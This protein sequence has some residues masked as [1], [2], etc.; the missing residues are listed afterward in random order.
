MHRELD[1]LRVR[2]ND[3]EDGINALI[4]IYH[5]FQRIVQLHVTPEKWTEIVGDVRRCGAEIPE[6]ASTDALRAT[7]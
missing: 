6:V 1:R 3:L 2:V 5:N 7:A 4:E